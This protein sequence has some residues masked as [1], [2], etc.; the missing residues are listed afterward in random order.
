[1]LIIV[2]SID[3]FIRFSV[4]ARCVLLLLLF[5]I[6]VSIA[7]IEHEELRTLLRLLLIL[8]DVERCC[9]RLVKTV[10]FWILEEEAFFHLA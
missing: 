9:T 10:S 6:D 7:I 8:R 2:E 3:E 4:H 5:K 1:M